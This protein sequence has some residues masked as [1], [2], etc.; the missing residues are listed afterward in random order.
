MQTHRNNTER[1]F[2]TLSE[3]PRGAIKQGKHAK[4]DNHPPGRESKVTVLG[5]ERITDKE[6]H[7]RTP[8]RGA[9]KTTE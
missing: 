1:A 2:V 3:A 6:S 4:S 7:G 5:A 8:T 9:K